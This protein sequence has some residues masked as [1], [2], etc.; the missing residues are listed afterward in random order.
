MTKLLTAPCLALLLCATSAVAQT[1]VTSGSDGVRSVA[2]AT[3]TDDGMAPTFEEVLPGENG[4]TSSPGST[5]VIEVSTLPKSSR[6]LKDSVDLL[7]SDLDYTPSD[8]FDR[9]YVQVLLRHHEAMIRVAET[10][11]EFSEDE[12]LRSLANAQIEQLRA[13]IDLL[14]AS[15]DDAQ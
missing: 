10:V 5:A 1:A 12:A 7:R 8:S 6:V 2:T 3:A 9:D 11:L 14:Q 4:A 13:E 15:S